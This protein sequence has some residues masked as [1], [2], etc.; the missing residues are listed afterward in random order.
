[1]RSESHCRCGCEWDLDLRLDNS[2][3]DKVHHHKY[4]NEV[5]QSIYKRAQFVDIAS[6]NVLQTK[7]MC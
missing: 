6:N 3:S 5:T 1:M 2:S 7:K 4:L